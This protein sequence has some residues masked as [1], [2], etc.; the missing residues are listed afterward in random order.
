ML[1]GRLCTAYNEYIL[2]DGTTIP[3]CLQCKVIHNQRAWI[4]WGNMPMF[5]LQ[6]DGLWAGQLG[7][8]SQQIFFLFITIVS[9]LCD[10]LMGGGFTWQL[11]FNSTYCTCKLP[12]LHLCS[13]L[14]AALT[15]KLYH[16]K[17]PSLKTNFEY[18]Y[19]PNVFFVIGLDIH[20]S[21]R[22]S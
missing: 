19:F 16:F 14:S 5:S 2:R 7:F 22:E 13:S 4:D 17:E 9:G 3:S 20:L 1:Q 10:P 8:Y 21:E 18:T 6:S 12:S 15:D 11:K